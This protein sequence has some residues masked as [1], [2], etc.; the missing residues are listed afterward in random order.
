MGSAIDYN[1]LSISLILKA[2]VVSYCHPAM[3]N[4]VR[5]LFVQH[6]TS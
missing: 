2:A 3:S 5:S 1:M 6:L 4:T